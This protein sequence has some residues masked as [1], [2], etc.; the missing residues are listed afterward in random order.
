MKRR[1]L[2]YLIVLSMSAVALAQPHI[3]SYTTLE[4]FLPQQNFGSYLRGKPTGETS[5]MMG[6]FTS[7]AEVTY[8]SSVDS[9]ET[10][11]S[12]KITDMLNLPSFSR[13]LPNINKNIPDGYEKT[14]QY[15]G[16][17]ILEAEDTTRHTQRLQFPLA[18]RFLVDISGNGDQNMSQLFG[19]LDMTDLDGLKKLSNK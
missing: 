7:W 9:G 2:S 10:M 4:E 5:S 8:A 15:K 6:F 18:G 14:V 19:L 12:V 1:F 3:V 16:R 17:K 13:I 11:I